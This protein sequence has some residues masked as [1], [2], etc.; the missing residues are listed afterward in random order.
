MALAV[1]RS[2]EDGLRLDR[3]GAHAF[4]GRRPAATLFHLLIA[5]AILVVQ[6][7]AATL[8]PSGPASTASA[9][10]PATPTD[11]LTQVL[12]EAALPARAIEIRLDAA[13]DALNRLDVRTVIAETARAEGYGEDIVALLAAVGSPLVPGTSVADDRSR[14]RSVVAGLLSVASWG[15]ASGRL[16]AGGVEDLPAAELVKWKA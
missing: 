10:A 16:F 3:T 11:G 13:L 9:T 8:P 5:A 7:C 1:T 14:A 6:A 4:G 12:C 2:T 15:T